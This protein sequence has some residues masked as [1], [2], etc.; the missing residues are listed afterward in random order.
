LLNLI[1]KSYGIDLEIER[2]EDFRI[3]RSLDSSRFRQATGFEPAS[4][5]EMT[6]R[7]ARDKTPYDEWRGE[8]KSGA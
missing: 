2:Y 5:P 8:D 3:D 4:W 1:K 6:D 7:M